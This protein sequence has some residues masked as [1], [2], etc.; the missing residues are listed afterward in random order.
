VILL[1][2]RW[3]LRYP[4]P[5]EHVSELLTQRKRTASTV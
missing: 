1:A 2:V 3:Y 5:Y 4:L